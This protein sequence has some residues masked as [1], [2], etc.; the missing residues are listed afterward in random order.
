MN[1]L[2]NTGKTNHFLTDDPSYSVKLREDVTVKRTGKGR[3][4][5]F[6][7]GVKFLSIPENPLIECLLESWMTEASVDRLIQST[8][9]APAVYYL[10]EKLFFMGLLKGQYTSDGKSLFSMFPAPDWHSWKQDVPISPQGLTPGVFLRNDGHCFVLEAP[11]SRTR[12]VIHDE[13]CLV[14]L[15]EIV[16]GDTPL[17]VENVPRMAFCRALRLMGALRHDGTPHGLWEFHDL[18][19]FHHS[20]IGF[21]DDPI[22]ATW[23]LKGKVSPEPLLKAC[24]GECVPLA[25]P[26]GELMK[27]LRTPFAEVLAGRRSGRIPGNRLLT[28]EELGALLYISARVQNVQEDSERFFD[29]SLRPSPSGGALHSLEIYPMVRQCDGLAS[30]AWRYDPGQHQLESI[31]TDEALLDTYLKSS[32]YPLVRGAGLP[33]IRL[34]I[35]SRILR[36]LW[37]Y[38]KIAYRL[39]LQD[40]GCLYQTL[41]LTAAAMGLTSCILGAVDARRLGA[42]MKLDPLIEPVVGEMTVSSR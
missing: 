17:P 31:G 41:G 1:D 38:E 15:M 4:V 32:P 6:R 20:S 40:L 35:T 22:G 2:K 10:C 34:V 28:L 12:C 36:D 30:G 9:N 27:K 14:W 21:H 11:L 7:N 39:V 5:L 33:H 13:Q 18:L 16:R 42:I 3:I 19:F 25:E 29:I 37:K 23:R 26:G 24:T 8:T